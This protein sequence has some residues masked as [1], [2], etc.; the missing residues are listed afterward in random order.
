LIVKEGLK[1]NDD[2]IKRIR[3]AV[4]YVKDGPT[5]MLNFKKLLKGQILLIKASYV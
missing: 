2:S 3:A 4:K 5:R 1:E